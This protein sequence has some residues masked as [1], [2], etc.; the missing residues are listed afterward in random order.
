MVTENWTKNNCVSVNHVLKQVIDW[1]TMTL[2][3][4]VDIVH[5]LASGQFKE[6]RSAM[7][8][9]GEYR[10]AESH[11]HFRISKTERISKTDAQ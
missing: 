9:T 4:F 6:L 1:R 3:E 2:T 10:L 8:A 11:S 5:D 7:L